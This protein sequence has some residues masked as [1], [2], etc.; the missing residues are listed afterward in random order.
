MSAGIATEE[1]FT[2][3]SSELG[4]RGSGGFERVELGRLCALAESL[5]E[6][7]VGLVGC[8]RVVH[9]LVKQLL[10]KKVCWGCG[11]EDGG[12]EEKDR[13]ESTSKWHA[14]CQFKNCQLLYDSSP[15]SLNLLFPALPFSSLLPYLS[16]LPFRVW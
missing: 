7:G 4:L 11:G 13:V 1:Q 6:K 16:L 5:L 3:V 14:S 2:A 9:P 10:G 15:L 8:Q 12:K